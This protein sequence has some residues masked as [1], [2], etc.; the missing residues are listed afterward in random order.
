M[1]VASDDDVPGALASTISFQAR[2]GTNYQIVVD[3]FDGAS[4]EIVLTLAADP[5]QL[6]QSLK[7]LNN[8]VQFNLSGEQGRIYTVEASPDL[9]N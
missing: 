1:L 2:A 8:R 7:V 4:G 9:V 5:P 3:G 6:G